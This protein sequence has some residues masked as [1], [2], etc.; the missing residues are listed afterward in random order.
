MP[1]H[2]GNAKLTNRERRRLPSYVPSRA[3]AGA[4]LDLLVPNAGGSTTLSEIRQQVLALPEGP[5]IGSLGALLTSVGDDFAAFRVRVEQWYDD[6]MARVSGWYKRH[7]RWVSLALGTVL[8]LVFNVNAIEVSRSL[9]A[10]EA[11]RASVV[12]TAADAAQCQGEEPAACLRDLRQ[13]IRQPRETA[14]PIGWGVVPQCESPANCGWLEK[15]GLTNPVRSG[16][17]DV[18]FFL[19][20]ACPEHDSGSTC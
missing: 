6:H 3:F 13:E 4:L 7:I 8:V 2:A 15:Y 20:V 16:I 5:L 19:L 1:G 18:L 9:Y 17:Y 11:L 14:L 12:A 10:D